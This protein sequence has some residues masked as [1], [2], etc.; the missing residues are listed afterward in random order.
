MVHRDAGSWVITAPNVKPKAIVHFLGGAFAGAAPQLLYGLLLECVAAAGYTVIATPYAVT[1]KHL[2]CAKR[3]HQQFNDSLSELRGS[4]GS[5]SLAPE[6]LPIVGLGHSNGSLLHLLIGSTES[7]ATTSNVLMS[8]NNKQV[9]DAIPVPGLLGTL[10]PSVLYARTALPS[11]PLPSSSQLLQQAAALLPSFL[12]IDEGGQ[13][14]RAA[15]ALDQLGLVVGE[16]GDGATDFEPSPSGSRQLVS[17]SY[18]IPSTLLIRFYD[19]GIDETMEM[20]AILKEKDPS[21]VNRLILPGS[22][23]TPCGGDIKWQP[24]AQFSVQD[25]VGQLVKSQLQADV[26]RLSKNVIQWFDAAIV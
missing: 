7:T 12:N 9:G 15:L 24:G 20:D 21:K 11:L 26:R 22:H 4:P 10:A 18:Q 17:A 8:Y 19:D 2:D 5:R 23:V 25:A 16:V 3:V 13:L 14:S 6:G 1:F